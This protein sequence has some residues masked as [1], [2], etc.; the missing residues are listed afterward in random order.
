MAVALAM[1]EQGLTDNDLLDRLA[2]DSRLGL[3]RAELADLVGTPL[4]FTGAAGAQVAAVVARVED[5]VRR[6]PDAAAYTPASIL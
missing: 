2:T 6:H 4:S 3:S 5:V 1:R